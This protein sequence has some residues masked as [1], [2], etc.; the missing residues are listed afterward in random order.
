MASIDRFGCQE[1]VDE[2]W[3]M[4]SLTADGRTAN[5]PGFNFQTRV[6]DRQILQGVH[7][8]RVRFS[9]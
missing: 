3:Q 6:C 1:I 5:L 2:T 7:G 9:S 8:R 4:P